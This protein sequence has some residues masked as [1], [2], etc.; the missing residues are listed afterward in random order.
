M[1]HLTQDIITLSA[2]NWEQW[3]CF[4]SFLFIAN[5]ENIWLIK[6]IL[7]TY[8]IEQQLI[9]TCIWESQCH[10][11]LV[12]GFLRALWTRTTLSQNFILCPITHNL[13]HLAK[14]DLVCCKARAK[15]E[16]HRNASLPPPTHTNILLTWPELLLPCRISFSSSKIP[17]EKVSTP[18]DYC[19]TQPMTDWRKYWERE[20]GLQAH[21]VAI[22]L[23]IKLEHLRDTSS[24]NTKFFSET[25]E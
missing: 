1:F 12:C 15:M 2:T 6:E 21:Y 25:G 9:K 13:I 7:N 24:R 3:Q 8:Y 17:V 22:L 5:F 19:L 18:I 14:K 11:F 10:S 4:Q 20:Q 23:R 16:K